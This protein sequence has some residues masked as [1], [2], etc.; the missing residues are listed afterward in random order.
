[1]LK[2]LKPDVRV[3]EFTTELHLFADAS[4]LAYGAACYI[5]LKYADGT[6]KVTFL[7]GKSRLA[8]IKFVTIPKLELCAAVLAAKMCESVSSELEHDVTRTYF[9]ATQ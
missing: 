7:L 8:P 4:E 9:G 6:V 1:M 3:Y 5:K 2:G